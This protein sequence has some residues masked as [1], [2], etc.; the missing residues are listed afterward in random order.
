VVMA[1]GCVA[2]G[3]VQGSTLSVL[4][5]VPNRNTDAGMMARNRPVASK[6]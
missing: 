4:G 5:T 6:L 3:S 2:G 1:T